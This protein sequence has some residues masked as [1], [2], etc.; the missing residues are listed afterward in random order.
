MST[1]IS[2]VTQGAITPTS[3]DDTIQ[4]TSINGVDEKKSETSGASRATHVEA[5]NIKADVSVSRPVLD[6]PKVPN[7]TSIANLTSPDMKAVF[8]EL[9]KFSSLITDVFNYAAS[10]AEGKQVSSAVSTAVDDTLALLI[11]L[12]KAAKE[13]REAGQTQREIAVQASVASIKQQVSE[14][15]KQAMMMIGMA[16]VS[17]VMAVASLAGGAFGAA[18]NAKSVKTQKLGNADIAKNNT[19]IAKL[20]DQAASLSGKAGKAAKA[21][22]IKLNAQASGLEKQN[23][24]IKTDIVDKQQRLFDTRNA[25]IQL[26]N[27]VNQSAGQMLNSGLQVGQQQSQAASKE[28]EITSTLAQ[29]NKQKADEL[30]SYDINFLR[31]IVSLFSR[32]SDSQNQAWKAAAT[33]I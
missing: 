16:V 28:E 33:V 10:A 27:T 30:I 32:I 1:I 13:S 25:N 5:G 15:N 29:N 17:G 11:L 24:Q 4:S 23:A 6:A 18:K 31:D 20:Q 9:A 3:I 12:F 19:Q 8:S 22:R 2:P 21:D 7:G 14:M 26:G